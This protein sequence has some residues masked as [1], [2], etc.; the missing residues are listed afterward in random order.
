[1]TSKLREQLYQYGLLMRL[2]KPVGTLLLLWPTLWALWIASSGEPDPTILAIFLIGVSVMRSAGCVI[3][4]YADR[5]IDRLV[6]RTRNRPLAAGRVTPNQT[7]GLFLG[8]CFIALA[9]V[10]MLNE[11]TILLSVIGLLLAATYPFMKRYTYLPQVHL[12]VAFGW[13]VPMSFAAQN[14]ALEPIAWLLFGAAVVWSV[15]YDTQYAMVDREDDLTIGVKSTAI[16]FADNDRLFVGGFQ[17]I[18][19]LILALVGRQAEL[20]GYYFGGLVLAA[21][22]F[23]YQQYLIR[24]RQPAGCVAAFM[25]NNWFGLVVFLGLALDYL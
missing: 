4:D 25:N 5:H 9:L 14:G 17:L 13:A 18:V 2:D 10:L 23:V 6:S 7:L 12:G 8:L 24:D 1:M 3:N 19:I 16:L 20:G 15:V 21:S 22:L 11:L